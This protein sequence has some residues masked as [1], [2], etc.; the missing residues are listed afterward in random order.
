M[1]VGSMT[2]SNSE[3]NINK[4]W[5]Q[6]SAIRMIP[7][8]IEIHSFKLYALRLLEDLY[9]MTLY[10]LNNESDAQAVVQESF[11]SAYRLWH[12]RQFIPN[13]PVW[14]FGI[15]ADI[16]VNK[17]RGAPDLSVPIN[18]MEEIDGFLAYSRWVNQYLP[19]TP[20]RFPMAAISENDL[21]QAFG[22][23]PDDIRLITALSMLRG[24]SYRE[25]AEIVKISLEDVKSGLNQ[26]RKLLQR[27]LFAPV[28]ANRGK[29]YG[30]PEIESQGPN[31]IH[32]SQR[33]RV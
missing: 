15:M 10:V 26:G 27:Q 23:L 30:A 19:G 6:E 12:K 11:V 7:A 3:L 5:I 4:H 33:S 21:R 9:S 16:I 29:T 14:L 18:H 31:K 25:I 24:F 2:L 8:G 13:C 1:K 22:S 32:Q 20:G 17:Y 28:V